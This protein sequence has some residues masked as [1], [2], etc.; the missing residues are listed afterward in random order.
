MENR[1]KCSLFGP[2]K[3]TG[4]C[5]IFAL[6]ATKATWHFFIR[7][8]FKILS[9]IEDTSSRLKMIEILANF[10]RSVFLLSPDDLLCSVYLVLNQLAP[11]YLG[12]FNMHFSRGVTFYKCFIYLGIELGVGEG[13][14]IKAIAQATGRA[15]DKV[16]LDAAAKGDLGCVAEASKG[17]QRTLSMF[18]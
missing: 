11:A 14:I 18:K 13:I 5:K 8:F 2:S 15:P 10:F 7:L 4:A 9:Q 16:K 17:M 1:R 3:N 12:I 6:L